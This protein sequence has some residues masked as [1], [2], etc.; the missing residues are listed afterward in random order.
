MMIRFSLSEDVVL[1]LSDCCFRFIIFIQALL[2]RKKEKWFL[3]KFF[4]KNKTVSS[5]SNMIDYI[6]MQSHFAI[7]SKIS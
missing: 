6:F 2:C 7:S 3:K 1:G 5:F 4:W